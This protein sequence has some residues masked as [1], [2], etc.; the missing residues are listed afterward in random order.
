MHVPKI[1]KIFL[2]S[3]ACK[4]LKQCRTRPSYKCTPQHHDEERSFEIKST[5]GENCLDVALV[6]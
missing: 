2:D 5:T 4:E 6:F 1:E 3:T